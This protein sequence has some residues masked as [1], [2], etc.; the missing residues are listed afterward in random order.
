MRPTAA[1][2]SKPSSRCAKA[3]ATTSAGS[4]PRSPILL[5]IFAEASGNRRIPADVTTVIALATEPGQPAEVSSGTWSASADVLTIT[6]TSGQRGN[7]QFDMTLSGNSLTLT[8]G[9][10][11]YDL[12]GDD[13]DDE[14][15]LPRS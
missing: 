5:R 12:N 8:G 10:V 6:W 11:A 1:I 13:I 7:A 9:H 15:I 2:A 4:P 3:S 14:S